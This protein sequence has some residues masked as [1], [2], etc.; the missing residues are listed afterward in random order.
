[1]A[2]DDCEWGGWVR[3]MYSFMN[4]QSEFVCHI[5]MLNLLDLKCEIFL[6]ITSSIIKILLCPPVNTIIYI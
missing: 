4:F 1:M 5:G 3:I 2:L 6:L